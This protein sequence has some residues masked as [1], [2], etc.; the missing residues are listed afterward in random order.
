[1]LIGLYASLSILNIEIEFFKFFQNKLV[2][3][4]PM[5][6]YDDSTVQRNTLAFVA[7]LMTVN[8]L[9]TVP[10]RGVDVKNF[11]KQI[12]ELFRNKIW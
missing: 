9:Q 4:N 2:N 12:F 6:T 1:M 11:L 3:R 10:F 8:L 7:P 5:E